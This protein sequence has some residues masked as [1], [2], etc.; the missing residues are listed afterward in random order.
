MNRTQYKTYNQVSQDRARWDNY[1]NQ[2]QHEAA[3]VLAK[4]NGR[5]FSLTH[6]RDG[7]FSYASK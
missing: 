2:H 6:Y 7:G 3:I 4:R 5:P 1:A